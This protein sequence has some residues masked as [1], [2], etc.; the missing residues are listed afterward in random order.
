MFNVE[1]VGTKYLMVLKTSQ[2]VCFWLLGLGLGPV[3]CAG[4]ALIS[5]INDCQCQG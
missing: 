1:C 3:L 2:K 4:I 5:Y